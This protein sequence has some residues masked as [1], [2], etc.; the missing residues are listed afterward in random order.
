MRHIFLFIAVMLYAH[1]SVGQ[2]DTLQV[3]PEVILS[4]VKLRE[5]SV[6]IAIQKVS[7]SI[8]QQSR[9]SLTDVL[10]NNTSIYFRENGPGGVSSAS[11]R[12]TNASQTAVVWNGININSQLTGQTDFNTISTNNYDNLD[13]R[14]GGGSIIYGSGAIGGSVHLNNEIQFYK[15]AET[16]ISAGYGSFDTQVAHAKTRFSTDKFYVDVGADFQQSENDFDYLDTDNLFNANGQYENLDLNLNAGYLLSSNG[17]KTHILKLHHNTYV[18]NR[19]FSGTLTAPS[20]DA[21]EDRNTRTLVAWENLSKRYDGTL[22]LAHIYEQFRYFANNESDLNDLGKAA[23]YLANYEG[24]LKIDS[25]KR[26]TF[27]GEINTISAA[28]ASI[29]KAS[30][31]SAAAVGLWKHQVLSA[32]SYEIQVRQEVVE[33]YR[34][35]FL[36]G[37]GL[38][39]AFAKAY[40]VS[41]NASRNY[42]VPTFNDTYWAGPGAMGNPD[43]QP[44]TSKQA[45]LG[46]ARSKNNVSLGLRGFYIDTDDLIKW[47]PNSAGIWSAVNIADTQHYGAELSF[48]LDKKLG[49][50]QFTATAAYAYTIAENTETNKQLIYVPKNKGTVGVS[51]NYSWLSSYVQGIYNG[52]VFTTTDNTST[53]ES[54]FVANAGLTAELFKSGNHRMILSAQINNV[55]NTNYQTVAFRPNP[56][57]NFL[58]QTTYTF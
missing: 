13:D 49:Q 37:V 58:I 6:G 15:R 21:Y 46:I 12:G 11:F 7:D 3:L 31:T 45:E 56:G 10:K 52:S 50:H 16:N 4:D 51:H 40:K 19:N 2:I 48:K 55:L 1:A 18:G 23:R 30:R 9:T 57:R 36:L 14:A 32:L 44:E 22:R 28:G 29:E 20:N 34:S 26:L 8:L 25:S 35:P 47:Q 42:R 54:S 17:D 43:I 39:Y 5:H 24:T 41:F 27:L 33:D 38:D 53:V